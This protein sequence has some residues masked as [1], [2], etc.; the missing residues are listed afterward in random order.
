MA[1]RIECQTSKG[2]MISVSSCTGAAKDENYHDSSRS[3]IAPFRQHSLQSGTLRQRIKSR[4]AVIGVVTGWYRDTNH[5]E[6]LGLLD[7]DFIWADAEHSSA[8]PD[9]IANIILAAER[10][11]LPTIVRIGYGY[12][13]LIGHVQK[14]LVAGACGIIVPQC[15]SASDV[16]AIVRATKF[17]PLGKRGLAP[18]RWN[19][20]GLKGGDVSTSAAAPLIAQRA[21]ESNENFIIGAMIENKIG[22]DALDDILLVDGLDFVFV[23]PVDLS[24]DL[25]LHGQIRHPLVVTKI[26]DI[27]QRVLSAGLPVGMVVVTKEDYSFWRDRGFTV[28]AGLAQQMF[29]EGAQDIIHSAKEYEKNEKLN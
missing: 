25:G 2:C 5:V 17:P 6:I 10:R 19:A 12:Q 15:E 1:I 9:D 21:Q 23:G 18:E 16:E 26:Q 14:Y 27:G 11:G 24:A 3:S 8:S 29:I 28:M 22:V 13:N 20:F 4:S 7:Y